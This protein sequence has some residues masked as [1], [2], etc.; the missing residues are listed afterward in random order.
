ME[1]PELT[2]EMIE[3]KAAIAEIHAQ[4]E[5]IKER[6]FKID[7]L[8]EAIH[9][10]IGEIKIMNQTICGIDKRLVTM[11]QDSHDR[12]AMFE[13]ESRKRKFAVWQ[14]LI[15]ALIGGAVSYFI[16]RGL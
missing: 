14:A 5:N 16:F 1:N 9:K 7:D 3:V 12:A 10:T 15:S 11:E 8:A 13:E 4:I 6:Q 2:R